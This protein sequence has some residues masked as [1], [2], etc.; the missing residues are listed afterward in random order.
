MIDV[1]LY[2]PRDVSPVAIA[3]RSARSLPLDVLRGVAILL[4]LCHH[5]VIPTAQAG[6]LAPVVETMR[7]FGWT[8]VDLFFVLSGFLIGGLLFDELHQR[9]RLDA[10]RF[11][12]RRMLKIWPPYYALIAYVFL[13]ASFIRRKDG[14]PATVA[15][16]LLPN[17]VHVQNYGVSLRVHTW[18]LAVEEHFYLLLPLVLLLLGTRERLQRFPLVAGLAIVACA[19]WRILSVA[20]GWTPDVYYETHFRLDGLLFGVLLA[21]VVRHHP[22]VTTWATR[23]RFWLGLAGALLLAPMLFFDKEHP[24]VQTIGFTLCYL[25]YGCILMAVTSGG[26]A[27]DHAIARAVGFV[28]LYSYS[29]YLWFEDLARTPVGMSVNRGL[30]ASLPAEARWLVAQ[31]SYFALA[32]TMG[33]VMSVLIE[34]PMLKLRDRLVPARSKAET[35]AVEAVAGGNR[36]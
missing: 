12:L 22:A 13:F 24:L 28:G 20:A 10:R 27:W 5:C 15:Y 14:S 25:G 17:L 6:V 1:A 18:S 2:R 8:G 3:P 7:R 19:A 35:L 32:V 33:C 11:L 16:K 30:L 9:G 23:H 26:D 31:L 34:R 29:I 4:V 21:Y 36:A